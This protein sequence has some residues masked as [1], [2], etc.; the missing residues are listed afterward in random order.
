MKVP[1]LLPART[2]ARGGHEPTVPAA[3]GIAGAVVTTYAA[4]FSSL[5]A[6]VAL[7]PVVL[8]AFGAQA[9]G[10]YM[11]TVA[12]GSLFQQDLGVG[13]ATTRFIGVAA[14]SGDV[15]R[16]RRVAAASN[17]FSVVIAVVLSAATGV[18][19]ALTVPHAQFGEDLTATAWML[20]ALGVANVFILLVFSANRQILAGV[21]RLND[22]NYLLIGLAVFRIVLTVIVCAAG[23]GIVAVA[24]VDVAGILAFGVATYVLR[25]RRAPE[26]TARPRDFRWSVF[27]ELFRVSSQLMVL[28]V[29]GVVIM[30]VGG[31]LTALM[32]P[33]AFTAL[34]AAGQ[35]IYLLVK[36]VTGS[37]AIA[38]LP[39]AS[40]REGGAD[41][42]PNGQLYLRGT[43]LAN[44]LMTLVLVPVLVFMP[45]I[46]RVWVGGAAEGA[47]LVAQ[48]L[49][50]SMFANNNH[51][52]AVPILTAQGS[53]RGYA[54]LHT[55]WAV[56][57]T[58]LAIV[59]GGPLGL[60]GIALGLA[61]PVVV[62]EPFYVAIALRRLD[63]RA[64]DFAVRCL[65]R[66]FAT[67]LPLAIGLAATTLLKPPLALVPILTGAWL[68]AALAVY[69]TI[70]VDRPTR[71]RA[72]NAIRMR[73]RP[74]TAV[75]ETL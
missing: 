52:L 74:R 56:S 42:T 69:L 37:L 60:P 71:A 36:E 48:I 6:Y 16:M 28:S 13:G 35:R 62:L 75:E 72:L 45:E 54:I 41:G 63:L 24:A 10:L 59:L 23:L 22:V 7:L 44:M 30:Q 43:S 3:G 34:Y 17:A 5:I 2:A 38:V 39:T 26:V 21:G 73:A 1:A 70:G 33:I 8:G 11:L 53:V 18:A 9:Y 12:I 58:L 57:G 46:M 47:A 25:R 19:F 50:L 32:L 49:V 65:V 4:R 15:A 66:P 40:M 61:I 27:R 64:R 67:V 20:S 55:V 29:A 31:I 14:P 68:V 51:L